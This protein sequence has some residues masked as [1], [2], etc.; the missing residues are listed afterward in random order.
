MDRIKRLSNRLGMLAGYIEAGASVI[1]VGADHGFL[2]VHLAQKGAARRII[3]SDMSAGSLGAAKRSADKRAVSHL[4]EF[5]VAP[6][7]DGVGESDVDT[8]VIAGVGGETIIGI[9]E[10]APWTRKG[11]RLILQPQTKIEELRRF[12]R[13][14]GYEILETGQTQDRGRTY[15]ILLAIGRDKMPT[16]RDIYQYLDSIA[17][18]GMKQESDNVGFLVGRAEADAS[19]ILVS[20]DITS[21]VISEAIELGA[22]LIVSHHPLIFFPLKSVTDTDTTGKKIVRLLSGGMSA[23][24]MHTNLDAARGG[25]NDALAI[26]AGIAAAGEEAE[27]LTVD[28]V[29][30]SGETYSY[31]RVGYLK[32]PVTL[33]EYLGRLK[34]ALGTSGLRYYGAGREVYKVAVVG[35]SGGDMLQKAVESGCDTFVT[36]DIKYHV[37]LE[38]KELGVNLIDGDHFCTENLVMRTV[39][40]KLRSAFPDSAVTESKRHKQTVMFF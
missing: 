28:G 32:D 5:I 4:I 19:K 25:V 37:F 27:L 17:P 38:A 20:L 8:I 10:A 36:A 14:N 2:P 23:I 26:A 21:Q 30:P 15:T 18:V 16:V 34:S 6:G 22:G 12:L 1:D 35:G 3:A 39:A 13:D 31:G 24:C 7:L 33:E 40:E 11:K 9:L 29:L